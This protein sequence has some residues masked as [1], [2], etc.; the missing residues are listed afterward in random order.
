MI[1]GIRGTGVIEFHNVQKIAFACRARMMLNAFTILRAV[2]RQASS[3][4]IR[5]VSVSDQMSHPSI[6][7]IGPKTSVKLRSEASC[8]ESKV[9]MTTMV[10]YR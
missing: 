9:A 2:L 4:V 5:L 8:P 7:H 1:E 6:R 3:M 10:V